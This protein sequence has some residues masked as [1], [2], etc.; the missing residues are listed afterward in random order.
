MYIECFAFN[1]RTHRDMRTH[2]NRKYLL[3]LGQNEYAFTFKVLLR[4]LATTVFEYQYTVH[5]IQYICMHL[6]VLSIR[7]VNQ[8]LNIK[9]KYDDDCENEIE[10]YLMRSHSLEM[11][12]LCERV[13]H[14]LVVSTSPQPQQPLR[15][16]APLAHGHVGHQHRQLT[17]QPTRHL[18]HWVS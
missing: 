12:E 11:Q 9:I 17:G 4:Y 13:P 10:N 2:G 6:R 18:T 16:H 14:P 7:I 8:L 5:C 1:S 15:G 3:T